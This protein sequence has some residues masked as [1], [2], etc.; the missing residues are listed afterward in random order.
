VSETV[1]GPEYAVAYDEL[2][3]DKDYLAECG[4]L[5]RVFRTCGAWPVRRVLDLGCG[6]GGHAVVLSSRGYAVVGVD[7]SED[8]LRRARERGSSA[9][10]ERGDI[11]G[12]DLGERFDAVVIMFA[13]MGYLTCNADI[14]SAL[15]AAR[16]H[17]EPGGLLVGDVWYGPAVLAQRPSERVKVIETPDGGQV[18]RAASGRLDTRRNVCTVEYRVWRLQ[19]QRLVGEVSEQHAMRYFFEP[20]LDAFLTDAGFD[21]LRVSGFPDIDEVPSDQTWNVAFV[22]R[23]V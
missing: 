5:E 21:L 12:V 16:R 11:T 3:H 2:Y 23:A 10:F 9:R 7:R 17:L 13:V 8:M 1:F 4:V 18:I 20:E 14:R 6:T 22:A 19:A 15:N